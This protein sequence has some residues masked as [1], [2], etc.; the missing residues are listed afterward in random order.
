[1]TSKIMWNKEIPA[2]FIP[3]HPSVNDNAAKLRNWYTE[4]VAYN[5]LKPYCMIVAPKSAV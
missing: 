1:M 2:H 5:N 3:L 4:H